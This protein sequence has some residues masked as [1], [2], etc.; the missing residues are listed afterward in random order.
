MPRTNNQRA[1]RTASGVDRTKD[2]VRR[3]SG[4]RKKKTSNTKKTWESM[5]KDKKSVSALKK[6]WSAKN[7]QEYYRNTIKK[8]VQD[9]RR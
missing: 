6:A 3:R 2:R 1:K 4:S 7:P 5:L 9:Y 8:L